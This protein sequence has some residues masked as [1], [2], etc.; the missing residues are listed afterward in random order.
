[1]SSQVWSEWGKVIS[2][3]LAVFALGGVLWAF[4]QPVTT[5]EVTDDLQAV[6]GVQGEDAPVT[7]FGAYV[8]ATAVVGAAVALW[9]FVSARRLRGPLGLLVC[10]IISFLGS[11]VFLVFG[12]FMASHFRATDLSGELTAGQSVT[13]I[14]DIDLGAA[15]LV[16]PA[17]ALLVYWSCA[18]FSSEAAFEQRT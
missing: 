5:G 11:G 7:A 2:V 14:S 8:I 16:A 10:G 12:N 15:S 1:M 18:L 17:L 6:V 9:V 3:S 4:A 13:L